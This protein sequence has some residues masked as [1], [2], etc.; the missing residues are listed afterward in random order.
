MKNRFSYKNAALSTAA[1]IAMFA[2]SGTAMAQTQAG[3][4]A[5]EKA[6]EI[7]VTGSRIVRN[8]FT[9]PQPVT[10]LDAET[11]ALS[12]AIGLG[13][14]LNELPAL[15]STFSLANSSR[16]IGTSGANFLDL[17]RLG[18]DR[19][20]VLVDGRRHV[21]SSAGS[22][23]VD[24][25]T[26]PKELIERVEVV[27]GGA[28][29]IYGS[30]AV[31]G[32][33]NFILK[34]DFEGVSLNGQFGQSE[35]GPFSAYT[36]SLTLGGNFDSD[37]GNAVLSIEWTDQDI[38]RT[39]DRSSIAVNPRQVRNSADLVGRGNVSNIDDFDEVVVPNAGLFIINR[40]GFAV[41][42][43]GIQVFNDD[44]SIRPI[45][46]GPAGNLGGGEC[47]DCDFLSLQDV[48]ILQPSLQRFSINAKADYD[49]T[50]WATF[51]VEGKFVNTQSRS[52]G[53]PAFDFGT[54][55]L[56][57]FPDN[58][59]LDSSVVDFLNDNN[60][61]QLEIRRF[62][63]DA[64]Q[65]GEANER[66]THRMVFGFEGDFEV[67]G[68]GRDWKYELAYTYGRTT[69]TLVANNNRVNDRF[70]AA[71]D[72]V[73]DVNG[74][75][76]NPGDV[77][78][79]VQLQ[80]A[81]GQTPTLPSGATVGRDI[82][83][84]CVPTAFLGEGNFS[85]EALAFAFVNS[86]REDSIEQQAANAF[87]SGDIIDL[88]AGPLGFAIG[89]EWRVDKSDSRPAGVDQLGITFGNQLF[90]TNGR[91]RSIEGFV[92]TT[93]PILAGLPGIDYLAADAAVRVSDYNTVGGITAWK[94]GLDWTATQD[95]RVRATYSKSVR[96]PNIDEVFGPLNQ[97]F[98]GYDDPCSADE[99]VNAPDQALRQA[100]CVAL[101]VPVGF[102]SVLDTRT[103]AGQS[104]GN[105]NLREE[106]SKSWTVGLVVT[107]RWVPG[108]AI[109]VDYWNIE[110]DDAISAPAAQD[111]LER[112]VDAQ[113]I[114]N[115][116]CPLITRSTTDFEVTNIIAL[117]QNL[118]A[119]EAS[120]V[121]FE[122]NYSFDLESVGAGDFGSLEFKVLGSRVIKRDDFPFQEFPND[123]ERQLGELGD[124]RWNVNSDVTW[125][126]DR[127]TLNY[128]N[129][130]IGSQL[131]VDNE[132]F[133][134]NPTN[135]FPFETGSVFYHDIQARYLITDEIQ[136]FAGVDNLGDK[137][138][139]AFL[140]G[141]GGGSAIFDNIGR[142]YYFGASIN[143]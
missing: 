89:G 4:E 2:A 49:L 64:G 13:D 76:G 142:H 63:V 133:I 101:G 32:V 25:N 53:Q 9:A 79:R 59:L 34:D 96:A 33:V 102:D 20:L 74:D 84:A 109:S 7:I 46:L 113:S 36:G 62:H 107:P 10:V 31:T 126:W 115:S 131:T 48:A 135:V 56:I 54:G 93:V 127:L 35:E 103:V 21:G 27:T 57:I 86:V 95:V 12:G 134:A 110:I 44:G 122:V 43:V 123:R 19:T 3:E 119:L 129:R 23:N 50:E 5:E 88:P 139:P 111:I 70:F 60:L 104:G 90:D 117:D 100:N 16:F 114:N 39:R 40:T 132:D 85:E 6:E 78:C 71:I 124:P 141:T 67:P 143:F 118:A 80:Q 41:T 91:I 99:L 51:F 105:P 140:T 108:L 66:Q 75:F 137:N 87:I 81:L 106:E 22:T 112:C 15:G 61:A 82:I 38:L 1:A 125:R 26:I 69:Q 68:L 94:F 47:Q 83:D 98:F 30:D 11:I 121:D 136:V 72:A 14:L 45:D 52:E 77:V 17:R 24:I 29:A 28:S 128:E 42:P 73:T 120:G 18:A 97:N 138:P 65:R 55:E 130:Y 37:R 92:E 58:P 116:F 8:G